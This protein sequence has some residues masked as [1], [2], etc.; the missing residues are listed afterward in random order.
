MTSTRIELPVG[1]QTCHYLTICTTKDKTLQHKSTTRPLTAPNISSNLPCRLASGD[2]TRRRQV[3]SLREKAAAGVDSP[4][5]PSGSP[6]DWQCRS[7]VAAAA[8]PDHRL[9]GAVPWNPHRHPS[10]DIHNPTA[11][12]PPPSYLDVVSPSSTTRISSVADCFSALTVCKL[13]LTR[14]LLFAVSQ[15]R[16]CHPEAGRLAPWLH[17]PKPFNVVR[18]EYLLG[19]LSARAPD[20]CITQT[21]RHLLV[22]P[23]PDRSR[24]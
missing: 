18:H 15:S 5:L 22:I 21:R 13:L 9:A 19:Q 23:S 8:R 14:R 7:A 24:E 6:P 16:R 10:V 4:K 3:N 17:S 11:R 12:R 1:W 2:V 20:F